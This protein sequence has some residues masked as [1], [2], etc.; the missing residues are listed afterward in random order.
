MEQLSLPEIGFYALAGGA[1]EPRDLIEE[2]R[3]AEA[4]GIGSAFVSERLN[5]KEAATISGALG[6]VSTTLGIATGVTNQNFRA[7]TVTAAH[8]TTMQA[9]THG[10]YTLGIGRGIVSSLRG[11][12]LEPPTT[13][14]LEDFAG[15]ARR[16][17]D[18]EPVLDHDGPAGTWPRLLI[19]PKPKWK[20]P[21]LITAF[22]PQT[23]KLA[24]RAFDAIVLHT[25]F[26]DETTA[27]CVKTVRDECERIGRDPSEVRIW[28]CYATVLS[29]L[30]EDAVLMKTVGRL[31]GYLQGYGDLMVKTNGWDPS[32]LER[33]RADDT[34]RS[35]RGA[36]DTIATPDQL[37]HI[38]TLIPAEW[39]S[40]AAVGTAQTCAELVD[41]QFDLGVD[42]VIMH[43]S[44]PTELSPIIAAYKELRRPELHHGLSNNPGAT[45]SKQA[46]P[47][48]SS[49]STV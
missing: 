7:P 4:L 18:G 13:A 25:F 44:S 8:A 31:S 28:S 33:F 48:E 3:V 20:T 30:P 17:L 24:A 21:L 9:L 39:L 34:V 14:Q 1:T 10:R 43:G 29:D 23:L 19:Q 16:V 37:R 40:A 22:G 26:S 46:S 49:T 32:V 45:R 41:R 5:L 35:I 2:A 36:I 42:G 47:L 12:G 11:L 6:A 15:V 27:K 38:Q